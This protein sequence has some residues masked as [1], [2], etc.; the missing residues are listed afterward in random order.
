MELLAHSGRA[1]RGLGPQ[2]YSEHVLAVRGG[3]LKNMEAAL[4]YRTIPEPALDTTVEWAA[5]FHD[6][7]KVDPNN[8]LILRTSER[9]KLSPNHVDAGAAHLRSVRQV[10][11]AIAVYGHH[12]GLCDLP[13]ECAKDEQNRQD[14][15]LAAL[16]DYRCKLGTDASLAELLA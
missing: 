14:P 10:E 12:I 4:R 11:A 8:Q 6:L 9:G 5:T 1:G 16:R 7:G 2:G 15:A 3:A 13:N